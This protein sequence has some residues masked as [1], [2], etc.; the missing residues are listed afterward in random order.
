MVKIKSVIKKDK[1]P[2]AEIPADNLLYSIGPRRGSPLA[3]PQSEI[4]SCLRNPIGTPHLSQMVRPGDEVVVIAD[5]ITRPTPRQLIIP[6]LLDELNQAGVQ[7]DD[8]TIL[9]ALGTHRY[10]GREEITECFGAKLLKRVDIINHRWEEP[11]ELV[12]AGKTE[13]GTPIVINRLVMEADFVL[14][15]GSIVP[16]CQAGWG[17]GAKIIQPGVCSEETTSETHMLA[18]RQDD[19]LKIAGDVDNPVRQEMERVAIKAGLRFILNVVFNVDFEV[20]KVVAGDPVKAH[21]EGVKEAGK[22]F[23]RPIEAL[24]DIVI[25]DAKPADIDYWQGI[26]PLSYARHGVKQ[27][28]I[29]ILVGDFPDGVSPIHT[30]LCTH[31]QKSPEKLMKLEK[32][33]ELQDGVCA[34]SLVLHG[35]IREETTVICVSEGI[36]KKDKKSLGFIHAENVESA[37]SYA[38]S[39]KGNDA[40]VGVIHHGGDTLPQLAD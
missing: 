36:S 22:I 10:M 24:A 18:A 40:K 15:V 1:F 4:T 16:H 6:P 26:K 19:Y 34:A 14:G 27:D 2:F 39:K 37:L 20:I 30:E 25:V 9:I 38:L 31:G 5:D 11:A 29:I 7:D 17:G 3:D 8:I 21:R 35:I 13:M 32:E 12:K 33:G 28:G 23:V